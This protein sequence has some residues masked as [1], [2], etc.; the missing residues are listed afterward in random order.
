MKIKMMVKN[1]IKVSMV[2]IGLCCLFSLSFG[3]I[4][5]DN[6]SQTGKQAGP[7]STG[8]NGEETLDEISA[9]GQD[10]PGWVEGN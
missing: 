6:R 3:T 7:L 5:Q 4:L 2:K 9:R 10:V 1:T 8:P